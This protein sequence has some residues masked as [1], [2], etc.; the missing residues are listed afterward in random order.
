MTLIQKIAIAATAMLAA[1]GAPEAPKPTAGGSVGGCSTRAYDNIGGPISMI[2]QTGKRVTEEDFKGRPTMVYFGFTYCPDVCPGTLV[3]LKNAYSRLPEG[4]APPRTLLITIDPERDTPEA[5]AA[6][7]DKNAFPND[8]VALTGTQEEVQAA[9]DAFIVAYERIETPESL[10]D[11][12]MDHT[13]LLYLMDEDW[14]LKT[15]FAEGDANP[16]DIAAC[17]AVHL[18]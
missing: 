14:K 5:L 13:S 3:G 4:I 6:Y 15:F 7:I 11:Y 8:L 18:K 17:L 12:T 10:S 9:A 1:C 16:E 2:D